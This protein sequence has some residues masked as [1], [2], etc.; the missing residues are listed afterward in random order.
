MLVVGVLVSVSLPPW[1][2]GARSPFSG[3]SK[4]SEEYAYRFAYADLAD[5]VIPS[6]VTVYVKRD[7]K[8]MMSDEEKKKFEE[9]KKFFGDPQLR[10]FWGLPGPDEG[11]GEG[12]EPFA[13]GTGSGVIVSSDGFVVTNWHV[14][15]DKKDKAEIR[16]VFA[17]DS[18]AS[19]K[20]VQVIAS[21]SMIDLALLKVNKPG[22][23]AIKFANSDKT[24]IGE[25]VA[26]I[27]SPL[28]LRKTVTQGIV[29]AMHRDVGQ[30]LGN[31]IQ[32]DAVI[33]PGSSGGALVN[34][35]GELVGINRMI[36]TPAQTGHWEGYGFAIPAN[37]VQY[38]IDQVK[39]HG[40]I[41]YGYIGVEMANER[42]DTPEKR[43]ALGLNKD[44]KGVLV[45]GVKPGQPAAAAGLQEGDLIVA[46]DNQ[47]IEDSG[48]LRN[49]VARR[50]VGTTINLKVLRPGEDVQPHAMNVRLSTAKRPSDKDLMTREGG[51]DE[52][53]KSTP[54]QG[55]EGSFGLQVQPYRQGGQAGLQIT[56]VAP[57]SPAAKAGFKP[58]DVILKIN[59]QPVKTLD[60]L[61]RALKA[62]TPG[63]SIPAYILH[64]G[65]PD[66]LAIK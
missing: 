20:D 23:A 6:V 49:Y 44:I 33:N 21:S 13:K 4:S 40:E 34:L 7:L 35:D 25:R 1:S 62:R 32:T 46:A 26:A 56:G 52:N 12:V 42:Q 11:D 27:G 38:F 43:E 45:M 66:F 31:M 15:G 61:R 54:E 64:N 58:G 2:V 17:D 59:R 22:L 41:S 36:A 5:K 37:D 50:P 57:G 60:D 51:E 55:V 30:G 24:R 28:E 8:S 29:S 14:V 9:F 19:G 53:E 63:K 3:S 47:K 18:E 65:V 39:A 16:I 10:Q 48:D